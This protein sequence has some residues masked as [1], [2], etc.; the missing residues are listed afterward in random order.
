[1][2]PAWSKWLTQ[3]GNIRVV[4]IEATE[5]ARE[6][7]AQQTLKG[8]TQIGFS[9]AVIGS[10]LIAS[11][12]KSNES[13]NLN[14][15][16]SGIYRQVVV[17]ASPEGQV[18]GFLREQKDV[19]KH[20]F[21]PDGRNGPWG[22]GILAILY[23]KNF[24]GKYPYTGMVPI[25]T[26]YLDDAINEYYRD[27]EQLPSKVGLAVDF[28]AAGIVS[29]RGVLVQTLGGASSEEIL[30]VQSLDVLAL[31]K[32]AQKCDHPSGLKDEIE[33][34]MGARGFQEIETVEL[35]SFC[36]CSQER[37][38]RAL[39]LSGREAIMDA[40]EGD[41]FLSVTCDFCRKEY[42]VSAERVKAIFS[43]DPSRIQ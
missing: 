9:E 38:E 8:S 18:R 7:S 24:E 12:H 41:P 15:Q 3:P 20:S 17:D 33:K 29:A 4:A 19:S 37:I 32:L 26:G 39:V 16:G 10:L 34:V 22:T 42:R 11:A 43:S 30:A 23:T 13:I 36:N 25:T 5:L 2:K 28:S 27:S 14:A 40:L 35:K 21:G 31:R 1:M 6:L